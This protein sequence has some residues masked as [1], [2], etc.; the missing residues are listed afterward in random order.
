MMKY[1]EIFVGSV[2]FFILLSF[3]FR[4]LILRQVKKILSKSRDTIDVVLIV[5]DDKHPS[6]L[7]KA[8]KEWFR[9]QLNLE[10]TF[11]SKFHP[12]EHCNALIVEEIGDIV[13]VQ[14]QGAGEMQEYQCPCQLGYC[15]VTCLK[16]LGRNA[17]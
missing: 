7:M 2:G 8:V 1:V 16:A 10:A 11:A 13:Y 14:L 6:S 5:D 4:W 9:R 12:D 3:Y 17:M 15:Q